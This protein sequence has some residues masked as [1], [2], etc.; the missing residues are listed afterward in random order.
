MPG[1]DAFQHACWAFRLI[2]VVE[3][4]G[5]SRHAQIGA[6]IS[7]MKHKRSA[8]CLSHANR[9][10]ELVRIVGSEPGFVGTLAEALDKVR[11]PYG[12]VTEFRLLDNPEVKDELASMRRHRHWKTCAKLLYRCDLGTQYCRHEPMRTANVARR[13]EFK[14]TRALVRA[15]SDALRSPDTTEDVVLKSFMYHHFRDQSV[16]SE[17]Y[18]LPRSVLLGL[19]SVEDVMCQQN[20]TICDD[21]GNA[22]ETDAG[23][24]LKAVTVLSRAPARQVLISGRGGISRHFSPSDMVIFRHRVL[25]RAGDMVRVASFNKKK[26]GKQ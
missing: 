4:L 10:P 6:V 23:E 18:L 13:K 26:T 20:L 19:G 17:L 3:R 24:E 9:F 14:N 25:K 16:A 7:R 2:P 21:D 1:G 15:A 11:S 5:E 8:V 22:P 12:F